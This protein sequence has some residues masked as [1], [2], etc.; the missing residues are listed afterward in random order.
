MILPIISF[1]HLCFAEPVGSIIA[2]SSSNIPDGYLDC[3]GFEISS[4]EY[5]ELHLV[6]G[7][8]FGSTKAGYF[9]VPDLRG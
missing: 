4:K 9:K 3:D 8:T 6:I 5:P 2:H 7:E 1:L